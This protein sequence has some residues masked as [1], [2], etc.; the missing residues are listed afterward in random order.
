MQ[1][2]SHKIMQQSLPGNFFGGRFFLSVGIFIK[3]KLTNKIK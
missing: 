2:A 3:L 1:S